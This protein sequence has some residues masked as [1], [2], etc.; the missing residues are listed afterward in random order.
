[1][2]ARDR[3]ARDL[4]P[5]LHALH[6]QTCGEVE[7]FHQTEKKW[8]AKHAPAAD[9]G[10]LQAATIASSPPTRDRAAAEPW[11][12]IGFCQTDTLPGATLHI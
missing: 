11:V 10:E 3:G 2:G 7:R 1:M 4:L 6:P 8:L 12:A 5:P 9:I